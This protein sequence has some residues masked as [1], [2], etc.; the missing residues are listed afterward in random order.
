MHTG[1]GAVTAAAHQK[2]IKHAGEALY[3]A[4]DK[5]MIMPH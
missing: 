4:Q 2:H 1:C 3:G 5:N